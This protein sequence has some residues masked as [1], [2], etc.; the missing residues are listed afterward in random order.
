MTTGCTFDKANTRKLN[1]CKW[2]LTLID[3]ERTKGLDLPR[4]NVKPAYRR[5]NPFQNY[6]A[7]G[8]SLP[9]APTEVIE[10]MFNGV[11][12]DPEEN[13]MKIGNVF[14]HSQQAPNHFLSSSGSERCG[15]RIAEE[16][17]RLKNG[18]EVT[19]PKA[20]KK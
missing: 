3:K 9:L 10:P 18:K 17:G 7:K 2:G 5:A 19:I 13:L 1:C 11:F 15:K 14:D 6:C 8:A 4:A 12:G 16:H 20:E